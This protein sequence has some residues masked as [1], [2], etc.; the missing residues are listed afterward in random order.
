MALKTA[1]MFK[2]FILAANDNA[3]L[4]V[5]NEVVDVKGKNDNFS[6]HVTIFYKGGAYNIFD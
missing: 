6:N 1:K 5:A 4:L 2:D 3:V